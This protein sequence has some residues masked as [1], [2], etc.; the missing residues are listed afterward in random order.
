MRVCAR[1]GGVMMYDF[2]KANMWKRI[3]AWLFD[4]I[5]LGIVY[6]RQIHRLC[7]RYF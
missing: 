6:Y 1:E 3:S 5:L 4:F 7:G 2:Q